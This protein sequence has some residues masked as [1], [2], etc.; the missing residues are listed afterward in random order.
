MSA[1]DV[2]ADPR[3]VPIEAPAEPE[4]RVGPLE[5]FFDLVFVF[6]IT[7]VTTLMSE[8]PTWTG[9]GHGM[10]VLAALWW[11]WAAYAW[12]TNEVDTEAGEAR[13]VI[14]VAMGAALVA[15]LAV[16]HAF[17]GE[18]FTFACAYLVVRVMH[19]LLYA[20]ATDDV[21]VRHS[22][23]LLGPTSGAACA[24]LFAA[25]GADGALQSALWALALVI[26][27]GGPYLWGVD[28]WRVSPGHFAERHGL[29][30]IIA[31]GESIVAVG[32]G[33]SGTALDTDV[34]AATV[35]GLL[36]V[37]ALW[38]AYFD[39]VALVAERRLRDAP[40]GRV[41]NRQAR[42]AYSYLHL[43][44]VAGIILLALGV[45]KTLAHVDEP[46]HTV[47]AAALCGGVALYLLAH[48]AFRAR[49]VHSFN[50]HRTLAAAVC[51]ALIPAATRIDALGA[52][53]LVCGVC[54]ALI[55]YEVV[56]FGEARARVRATL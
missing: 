53:A 19:I 51:L 41:R 25:S 39:V 34:I 40:P 20:H 4:Q 9:L 49:N 23:L 17:G 48:V 33:A 36:L 37:A 45:K 11:A 7:Q 43:P 16:P 27:Y 42:D 32:A 18:A 50:P 5:L 21:G 14:F 56:R 35:L 29:I 28:G 3:G 15:S 38:W 30:V 44:M 26:D 55:A 8:H 52:L 47:P 31:L 24:L 54:G 22:A 6:A 1:V 12:L 13:L 2:G 46:L 10:L